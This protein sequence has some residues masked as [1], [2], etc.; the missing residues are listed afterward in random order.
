MLAANAAFGALDGRERQSRISSELFLRPPE[1]TSGLQ[2][3]RD[4]KP[5]HRRFDFLSLRLASA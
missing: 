4:R 5:T 3:L 1:K 2:Y